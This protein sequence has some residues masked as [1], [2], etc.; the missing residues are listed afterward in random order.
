M[1]L[2]NRV[3]GFSTSASPINPPG[4]V[5]KF[6]TPSGKFIF[7]INSKNFHAISGESLDGFITTVF[8]VTIADEVIPTK[9]ARGKFQGGI[10]TPTP[11]GIYF[12]SVFS[13]S[14]L[15]TTCGA[16]YRNISHA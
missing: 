1:K 9:I 16:S 12:N 4:P 6:K 8:P 3:L 7:F 10:T 5:I 13:V 2:T 14:I 15:V 11:S